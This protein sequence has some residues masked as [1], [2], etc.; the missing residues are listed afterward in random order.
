M[1]SEAL[2]DFQ[3][4]DVRCHLSFRESNVDKDGSHGRNE[5]NGQTD[6]E[7]PIILT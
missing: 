4:E 6:I 1:V 5:V 3:T 7:S 2:G